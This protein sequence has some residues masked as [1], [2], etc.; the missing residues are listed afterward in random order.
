MSP[1]A[2]ALRSLG[3]DPVRAALGI[4]GIAI[5]GALLLDML[6][7]SR[8]LLVS[9]G[10]LLESTG[11]EVRVTATDALPGMGPPIEEGNEALRKIAALPEADEAV[12]VRF[13]EGCVRLASGRERGVGVFAIGF[14]RRKEWT[15]LERDDLP[16]PNA[17]PGASEVPSLLASRTFASEAGLRPG[18][19]VKLRPGSPGDESVLPATEFR[20]AGI[21]SFPFD[22]EGSRTA[23]MGLPSF[24]AAHLGGD[25]PRGADPGG[26]ADLLLV[27]L[28]PG[29]SPEGA[30][31]AIRRVAPGL[32]VFSIEEF[33]ARFGRTDFSYFRQISAALAGITGF[34]VFL[35]VATLLTVSVNQRLGEVAALRALG[36]S[37][38]R[39]ASDLVAESAL[40]VGAGA[41]LS[42]PLG[43]A[44]A[45]VLDGI[46]R[47]MPGLP[48][49]L[50]FFVATPRAFLLHAL[51]LGGAALLAAAWPIG[52]AARLPIAATL[53]K[54]LVG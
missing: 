2:F 27:S 54:E 34:F 6:L 38:R 5:V 13:G 23:A 10:D 15:I 3:R 41:A 44:L 8:G 45:R 36:F 7:L 37:R 47:T 53:R 43:L 49:R 4:A 18:D 1:A 42:V 33:L 12:A 29:E 52:L 20:V 21:A 26:E 17:G 25:R 28:R 22:G 51:I 32:R 30:V 46:L 39:V 16:A 11:F 48:E 24:S 35:L 50:H 40:L 14:N 9:F 19:R 31:A